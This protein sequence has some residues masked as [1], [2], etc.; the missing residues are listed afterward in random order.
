MGD[1]NLDGNVA[2]EDYVAIDATLGRTDGGVETL[3]FRRKTKGSEK[4]R[5]QEGFS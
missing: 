1:L 5:G 4:Q 3:V 2:A